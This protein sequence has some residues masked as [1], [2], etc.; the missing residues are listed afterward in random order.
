M[1][2]FGDCST[3]FPPTFSCWRGRISSYS[4]P[5]LVIRRFTSK[6][7]VNIGLSGLV[8]LIVRLAERSR[9]VFSGAGLVLTRIMIGSFRRSLSIDYAASLLQTCHPRLGLKV[10][11]PSEIEFL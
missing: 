2:T 9:A 7:Q 8:W 11:D 3:G 4:S 5:I 1:L 6:R 10:L